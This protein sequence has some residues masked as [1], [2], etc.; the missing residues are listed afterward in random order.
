MSN[1]PVF[2]LWPCARRQNRMDRAP[3]FLPS[4]MHGARS[5]YTGGIAYPK[6]GVMRIKGRFVGVILQAVVVLGLLVAPLT[7]YAMDAPPSA[8]ATA[9]VAL[10]VGTPTHVVRAPLGLRLRTEP[11]LA[12]PVILTLQNGEKVRVIG[13]PVFNQ[14]IS[15]SFVRVKRG[16]VVHEG[17]AA[18][19][20]LAI[21]PGWV[22]TG[23]TG[24][25]VTA[26]AGL[27]LRSGPGFGFAIKRIVPFG[28]ILQPTGVTKFAH[29]IEW[30][31]VQFNGVTLWAASKWLTPI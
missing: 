29:G 23:E 24:L 9:P 6:E 15:W 2:A 18:T 19:A 10:V 5:H 20:Y 7:A 31:E 13:D 22:P 21:F 4:S 17:Y 16:H 14:G 12:A 25:K 26:P 8:V 3:S 11:N 27:R 28:T 30:T 1:D